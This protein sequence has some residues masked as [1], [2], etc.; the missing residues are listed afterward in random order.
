MTPE[1][2][3]ALLQGYI[4]LT[5]CV[6]IYLLTLDVP[7]SRWGFIVGFAAQPAWLYETSASGQFGMLLV[8]IFF[9]WAYGQGIWNFWLKPLYLK[10]RY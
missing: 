5:A 3:A 8:S 9:T 6:A 2:L 4:T 10:R 1:L 7:C